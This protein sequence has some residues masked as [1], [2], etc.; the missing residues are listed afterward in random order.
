MLEKQKYNI[1]RNLHMHRFPCCLLP[2]LL[3]KMLMLWLTWIQVSVFLKLEF[4][5][6][7]VVFIF[8]RVASVSWG[9]GP[10]TRRVTRWWT[11]LGTMSTCSGRSL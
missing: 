1:L 10:V 4:A 7:V 9:T 11:R 8:R 5:F 2:F 3:P 6:F